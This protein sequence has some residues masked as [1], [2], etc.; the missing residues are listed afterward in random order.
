MYS[1]LFDKHRSIEVLI[2]YLFQKYGKDKLLIRDYWDSDE[3][4]IGIVDQSEKYLI[5]I[6]TIC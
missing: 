1:D 6:S 3:Y 4:A 5:Y 2:D